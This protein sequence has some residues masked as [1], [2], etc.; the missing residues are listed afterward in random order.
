[1]ETPET[2]S[3]AIVPNY[4]RVSLFRGD[5]TKSVRKELPAV[6]GTTNAPET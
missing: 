1:M 3:N 6:G 5:V 4:Y 2:L